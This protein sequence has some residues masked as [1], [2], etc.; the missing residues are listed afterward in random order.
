MPRRRRG[1][2]SSGCVGSVAT[3]RRGPTRA[4]PSSPAPAAMRTRA[5][6]SALSAGSRGHPAATW[7]R[8]VVASPTAST[9]SASSQLARRRT[10][11]AASVARRAAAAVQVRTWRWSARCSATHPAV[12]RAAASATVAQRG[13]TGVDV[14]LED[15]RGLGQPCRVGQ[16]TAADPV[17]R[18]G[19][20]RLAPA[21]GRLRR[22]RRQVACF[23]QAVG[24]QEQLTPPPL[25]RP[26][27]LGAE[28]ALRRRRVGETGPGTVEQAVGVEGRDPGQLDVD[29]DVGVGRP[30][31][32][33]RGACQARAGRGG[34]H[35]RTV[36]G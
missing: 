17:Q 13:R 5:T 36:P 2:R 24:R 35:G 26:P 14:A 25:T 23:G 22:R 18:P 34:G 7:R 27:L 1:R 10:T 20:G 32:G 30:R 33:G 4:R 8:A 19:G 21:P 29:S 31:R 6:V 16:R 9:W 11:G 3:R 12:T 15:L 28:H